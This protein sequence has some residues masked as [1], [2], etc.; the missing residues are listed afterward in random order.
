M[1]KG[2][3]LI[4]SILMM[5]TSA[6]FGEL[7]AQDLAIYYLI[8]DSG[9]SEAFSSAEDLVNRINSISDQATYTLRLNANL[10]I[11]KTLKIKNNFTIVGSN[12]T[13]VTYSDDF[14]SDEN[15][16]S[17]M[18]RLIPGD[19]K[20]VV[21]IKNLQI[22]GKNNDKKFVE[23]RN[24][25]NGELNINININNCSFTSFTGNIIDLKY[26][27]LK[28]DNCNINNNIKASASLIN[29]E[30]CESIINNC[31]FEKNMLNA[32]SIIKLVRGKA[33]I[34]G[35]DFTENYIEGF[36]MDEGSSIIDAKFLEKFTMDK[37]N[38]GK[39]IF[40]SSTL[41]GGSVISLPASTDVTIKNTVFSNNKG[42]NDGTVKLAKVDGDSSNYIFKDCIFE[43]NESIL[44]GALNLDTMFLPEYHINPNSS[45]IVDISD[46][47]FK[48][49]KAN[50]AG[51]INIR[52]AYRGQYSVT[53]SGSKFID[54]TAD[55]KFHAVDDIDNQ[56]YLDQQGANSSGGA[57]RSDSS[58]LDIKSSEFINNFASRT[59]GAIYY[60]NCGL[61][62]RC[63][64]VDGI[65][66]EDFNADGP[67]NEYPYNMYGDLQIENIYTGLLIDKDVVF[68]GNKAGYGFY[69]PPKNY[70]SLK[71]KFKESSLDGKLV[72]NDKGK[73]KKVNSIMNNF[74]LN[75]INP[76]TTTVYDANNEVGDIAVPEPKNTS[77]FTKEITDQYGYSIDTIIA[78]H[79][80][81][82]LSY[83]D[84]KLP[85][86]DKEL[87][88][89]S[90]ESD[91]SGE[92]LLAGGRKTL[93]GNLYIY[94]QYGNSK[95][96]P[97]PT[98]PTK[99]ILTLDE[100]YRGGEIT[101]HE[102][103]EG[104]LIAPY[105]YIPRRRGY[106]FRGWSYDRKHLDEV[107]PEDRIYT[108]TTL[109]AIWKKAEIE[110]KE[111]PEEIRGEDHKAYIFGYPNGTVRP[112][113]NI[114]RAEAA[115]MLARLLDIE[116]YGSAD[117][118]SFPDTP[119]SW[120]NKAINAV[121]ARG[122]MQGY[123]DGRFKPNAPITRAEFTQMISTIDNKPYGEAPFV[124][125]K[126]HWA[127][128]AIGS[129]YQA[130]RITG[131]PDGLF[132]P[133]AN[134][135]RAEAAVILNKI[136]ERNYDAMSL[137]KCKNALM[138]KRFIDLDETFWGYNDMVEATNT[139]EYVRR[140]KEDVMKRLEEDW[141]LIKDINDVK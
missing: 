95:P 106:I 103:E 108:D 47:I 70:A 87:S 110:K 117:A 98:E 111:E 140:Y 13:K 123:P 99:Y 57:I 138:L 107:K 71:F 89:W 114:T 42:N 4:L 10:E 23:Y 20:T 112:N 21:N 121:V 135:T 75:Y 28:L 124:D 52:G 39:C 59:G 119:S 24:Y 94:A 48:N 105:L 1:K 26:C 58:T 33:K 131:Y 37:N 27:I 43:N 82:I 7:R 97:K 29:A 120:Y 101:D 61:L 41:D 128:R 32:A 25:G 6:S 17:A 91:G 22:E 68:K 62:E 100:N 40:D 66:P 9:T 55:E 118:P 92:A 49:N 15:L 77:E 18:I 93:K 8:S 78:E 19:N 134:I 60:Y 2:L 44:S 104:E 67:E 109:Y 73:W 69:N 46:C 141:L 72:I 84:T 63:N 129:E 35:T 122:I 133:D 127:E 139:H 30:Y 54:N 90:L 115:A 76:V 86:T 85:K 137:A 5:L 53:I 11:P 102:L 12:G 80:V 14:V 34:F 83:K 50:T 126:G 125:V 96:T 45:N 113:G 88:K 132:R 116:A 36:S 130:K 79:N 31:K 81:N 136:F 16:Y 38:E 65:E 64:I 56:D 74:D 51:A 3:C